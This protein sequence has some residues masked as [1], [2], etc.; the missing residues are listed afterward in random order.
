M[1]WTWHEFL[2]TF[3]Q[4]ASEVATIDT[5]SLEEYFIPSRKSE[6]RPAFMLASV[7]YPLNQDRCAQ[8]QPN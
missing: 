6:E 7:P 1:T 5:S 3:E 4:L 2:T 8:V